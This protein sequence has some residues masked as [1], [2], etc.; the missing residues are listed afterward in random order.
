MSLDDRTAGLESRTESCLSMS[1]PIMPAEVEEMSEDA[2]SLVAYKRVP[3]A[4]GPCRREKTRCNLSRPCNSCIHRGRTE[5]CIDECV[6][7]RR[8]RIVC[9][10]YRPCMPCIMQ[11]QI[12]MEAVT[13]QVTK[14]DVPAVSVNG[15]CALC[16]RKN[17]KCEDRRPCGRC[18]KEGAVCVDVPRRRPPV[19]S[20]V[21][22]ACVGC[23]SDR[24]QCE[25]ARPCYACARKNI[26]CVD[27]DRE[28]TTSSPDCGC[29]QD[30]AHVEE[31]EAGPSTSSAQ[32]H[33]VTVAESTSQ[34]SPSTPPPPYP[35]TTIDPRFLTLKNADS[36]P[37]SY[38]LNVPSTHGQEA[39]D[40]HFDLSTLL[41]LT[42]TT[43]TPRK[44]LPRPLEK[45]PKPGSD[46][47][48]PPS[49]PVSDPKPKPNSHSFVNCTSSPSSSKD[50]L[51][52]ETKTRLRERPCTRS[53]AYP[54]STSTTPSPLKVIKQRCAHCRHK[55]KKCNLER[56][57]AN[58]RRADVPCVDLPRKGKGKGLKVKRACEGCRMNKIQ[59]EETR[60]CKG[61]KRKNIEC[62]GRV[63]QA[64]S[65]TQRE[66]R[67]ESALP[68]ELFECLEASPDAEA[69]AGASCS[70]GENE[71]DF[72]STPSASGPS[73]M[74]SPS[75]PHGE[76]IVNPRFLSL[77]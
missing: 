31:S 54:P 33:I 55:N 61:C 22:R 36:S 15:R 76:Y 67:E 59:C 69:E 10:E 64:V 28:G 63:C 38:V 26:E 75:G 57:C 47:P 20:R 48:N 30:Q 13:K 11:G 5:Q 12:C 46:I 32:G 23:R 74:S 62:V 2:A 9:D 7:C 14:Q 45:T 51:R 21:K 34:P 39:P 60:P 35:A 50:A 3:K 40:P 43:T 4:C 70:P 44:I 1:Y 8:N 65:C 19:G 24:I 77:L 25:T 73:S 58:C 71:R 18:V 49:P 52:S 17:R 37:S 66:R 29:S 72:A 42:G 27:V 53:G 68:V 6:G 16:A 56:P 41:A